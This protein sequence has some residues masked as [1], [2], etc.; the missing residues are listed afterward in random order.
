VVLLAGAVGVTAGA[1]GS[2]SSRGRR[3]G[4]D[5]ASRRRGR[6]DRSWAGGGHEKFWNPWPVTWPWCGPSIYIYYHE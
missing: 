4:R 3:S 2:V 5:G 1:R 6:G